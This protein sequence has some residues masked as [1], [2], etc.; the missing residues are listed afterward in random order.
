MLRAALAVHAHRKELASDIELHCTGR[1]DD[2]KNTEL[3]LYMFS[4]FVFVMF[5][6]WVNNTASRMPGAFSCAL[7]NRVA[8]KHW[9]HRTSFVHDMFSG[10]VFVMFVVWA[11]NTAS[12][13]MGAFRSL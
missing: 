3:R 7:F 12:L 9:G 10:F 1:P 6:V 2:L 8:A 13:L 11:F 5:V 4:G